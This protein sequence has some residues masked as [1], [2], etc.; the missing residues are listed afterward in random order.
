VLALVSTI[1]LI[2]IL[3]S[4]LP[5]RRLVWLEGLPLPWWPE[6]P[7]LALGLALAVSAFT[8]LKLKP[9]PIRNRGGSS[10]DAGLDDGVRAA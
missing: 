2:A 3:Q 8:V 6:F 9:T 5:V 7:A 4:R 1:A 10:T